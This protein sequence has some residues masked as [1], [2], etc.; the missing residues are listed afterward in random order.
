[1]RLAPKVSGVL[2]PLLPLSARL[3]SYVPLAKIFPFESCGRKGR[4]S[5][6]YT[7]MVLEPCEFP[8]H[9][10][11]LHD[12]GAFGFPNNAPVIG[13]PVAGPPGNTG[14]KNPFWPANVVCELS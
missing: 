3:T 5:A 6:L 12:T 4:T 7:R 9:P 13:Y 8:E 14:L 1:M 10:P 11:E 2:P